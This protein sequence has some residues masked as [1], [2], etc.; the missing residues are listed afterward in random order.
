MTD[1]ALTLDAKNIY[2]A[3]IEMAK[4]I[5]NNSGMYIILYNTLHSFSIVVLCTD[6]ISDYCRT[7]S[8]KAGKKN[9]WVSWFSVAVYHF[10][11]QNTFQIGCDNCTSWYHLDCV[12]KK[13]NKKLEVTDLQ[14]VDYVG[15]CCSKESFYV[16]KEKQ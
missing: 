4:I 10:S 8:C 14:N 16:V 3:R 15:P 9:V 6:D 1:S 11:F 5:L 2:D 13:I 7:C 12:N